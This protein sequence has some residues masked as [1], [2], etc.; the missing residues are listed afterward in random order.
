MG[1][2]GGPGRSGIWDMLRAARYFPQVRA[3]RSERRDGAPGRSDFGIPDGG[4][5][6]NATLFR[7]RRT[8]VGDSRWFPGPPHPP[9]I[10]LSHKGRDGIQYRVGRLV[11]VRG[12]P[13]SAGRVE[14]SRGIPEGWKLREE[15]QSARK[16]RD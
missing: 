16:A 14:V 1:R 12:I 15:A 8:I 7:E 3:R 11:T 5:R 10:A 13:E 4:V 9:R 2:Q 6:A